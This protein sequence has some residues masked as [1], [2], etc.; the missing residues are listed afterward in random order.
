MK[1]TVDIRQWLPKGNGKAVKIKVTDLKMDQTMERG[2]IR[3]INDDNVAKKVAGYPALPPP[4][5]L[6]VTA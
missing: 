3:A 4:G 1:F 2:Q 5:R 6:R